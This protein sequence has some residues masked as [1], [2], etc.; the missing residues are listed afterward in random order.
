[1]GLTNE[2]HLAAIVA[3]ATFIMHYEAMIECGLLPATL[4]DMPKYEQ[5]V[6]PVDEFAG[7]G[8]CIEKMNFT[9][10]YGRDYYFITTDART[11]DYIWHDGIVHT[12]CYTPGIHE[13]RFTAGYYATREEA[14]DT[15]RKY[16]AGQKKPKRGLKWFIFGQDIHGD[17]RIT[18]ED[19]S[20]Y[21]WH[22]GIVHNYEGRGDAE[23]YYRTH[24]EAEATLQAYL[25]GNKT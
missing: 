3:N 1:M 23:G 19:E 22:D 5:Q 15:L 25:K 13:Q 14:E 4:D 17:Y 11:Q 6:E 21:I 2:D 18:H 8:W 24:E 12:S 16:L 7:T 10:E 9:S 20:E